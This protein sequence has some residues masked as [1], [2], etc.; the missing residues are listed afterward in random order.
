LELLQI[1]TN[2]SANGNPRRTWILIKDGAIVDGEIEDYSGKPDRFRYFM[3]V[4][5]NVS[6]KEWCSWNEQ[7]AA[8][9]A[10]NAKVASLAGFRCAS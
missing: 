2:N 3:A 1:A 4:R 6:P 10:W 5:I 8:V 9:I 7:L